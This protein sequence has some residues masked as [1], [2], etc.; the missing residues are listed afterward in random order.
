MYRIA[1]SLYLVVLLLMGHAV[2]YNR[3]GCDGWPTWDDWQELR[4]ELSD[5]DLLYGPINNPNLEW[6]WKCAKPEPTVDP[7]LS[8]GNGICIQTQA[9]INY[10]CN[11]FSSVNLPRYSVEAKSVEDIQAALRFANRFDIAVSIKAG[12]H[13]WQGQNTHADSLLIWVRNYPKDNFVN[14]PETAAAAITSDMK[15]EQGDPVFGE[16]SGISANFIDS[17]GT[18]HGPTITVA[19]GENFDE[20]M[21]R[22]RDDYI[23][24]RG[25]CG[26][27][28]ASGGFLMGGGLTSFCRSFGYAVDQVKSF[29]MVLADTS[30][31][32]VDACSHP[33]LFWA[34]RGGGGGNWG[35]LISVEYQL[36]PISPF[37]SLNFVGSGNGGYDLNLGFG[38]GPDEALIREWTRFFVTHLPDT[39][40]KWMGGFIKP[41]G[42]GLTYLGTKEEAKASDLVVALD[43]WY[44]TLPSK[45]IDPPFDRPSDLVFIRYSFWDPDPDPEGNSIN[46][47]PPKFGRGTS[48]FIPYKV[49]KEET[50]ELI[51]L[52]S[53]LFINGELL[54]MY[55]LGGK[56]RFMGKDTTSVHPGLR[57]AVFGPEPEGD[58]GMERILKFA[59]G[60]EVEWSASYNH[61]DVNEK[62]W[63]QT[64]FGPS[65]DRLLEI[66]HKYD[67]NHRFNVYHGVDFREYNEVFKCGSDPPAV[68]VGYLPVGTWA[69]ARFGL[70]T[71]LMAQGWYPD[72]L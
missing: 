3:P 71:F 59:N 40:P 31:V 60:R 68:N 48:R 9:C 11:W 47:F 12:G 37:A 43:A 29:Q 39:D 8:Q 21:N 38:E 56:A 4:R 25:L 6:A 35:V 10:Q 36:H 20:V 33:D 72:W 7:S 65:Y 70:R 57:E 32:T 50:E 14:A 55:Y 19:A 22:V 30:Y 64:L 61:H 34:L 44:D 45:G 66:K 2:A 1:L 41:D 54:N 46:P 16:D 51:D 69:S 62:N 28:T 49:T 13:N 24:T 27:V 5:P 52:F 23:L 67:P 26:T 63:E 42:M 15:N 58:P 18:E 53:E 17:C